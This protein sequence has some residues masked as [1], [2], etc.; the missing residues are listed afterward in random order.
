MLIKYTANVTC[1]DGCF[2][3]DRQSQRT[4]DVIQRYNRHLGNLLNATRTQSNA[5]FDYNNREVEIFYFRGRKGDVFSACSGRP[6]L[7][8]V[9]KKIPACSKQRLNLMMCVFLFVY[10]VRLHEITTLY[11]MYM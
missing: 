6:I 1:S 7:D 9:N 10:I 2:Y 8:G 4:D 3:L 11:N 5:R